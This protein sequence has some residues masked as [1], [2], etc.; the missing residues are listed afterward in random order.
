MKHNRGFVLFIVLLF[1]FV[2]TVLVVSGSQNIILNHK[3]QNN[4][5]DHFE[6]F[7]EA[8]FGWQQA[9]LALQGQT[10]TLPDSPILLTVTTKIVSTDPCGNQTIDIQSVAKDTLSKVILNSRD[11]FA[12]VPREKGCQK[13]PAHHIL[14][15]KEF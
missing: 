15:W 14:W 4:T 2:L 10:I 11:I 9:V 12:R 13:I 6:V 3:M 1:L 7:T 5:Y 8:E